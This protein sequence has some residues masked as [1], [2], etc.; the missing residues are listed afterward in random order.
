MG[1]ST[2]RD[3]LKLLGAAGAATGLGGAGVVA[4]QGQGEGNDGNPGEGMMDGMTDGKGIKTARVR[5]GHLIPDAP[6]VDIYAF[7][8]QYRELGE[9]PIQTDLEYTAVRPNIP[10]E[11][12]D[13]P[14]IPLGIRVTPA[15]DSDTTLLEKNRFKFKGGRNQTVLAVGEAD[16]EGYDEPPVQLLGLV[17]NRD[18]SPPSY[19]RTQ[20]PHPDE[21]QVRFVHALP[22]AGPVTIE[23]GGQ[24]SVDGSTSGQET[25]VEDAKFGDATHYFEVDEDDTFIISEYGDEVASVQGGFNEGT[26]NTVYIVSQAPEPG[27]LK[28]FAIST[29]DA[30]ARVNLRVREL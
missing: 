23:T 30:A 29:V 3:I 12:A 18:E 6:P 11:Y 20:L 5:F 2:R 22:D 24:T 10:A 15:G 27:G 7:L 26:K 14:A 17:D 21:T 8:P 4:A 9:V 25:L 16:S 1:D 28:P 19:G 13:I